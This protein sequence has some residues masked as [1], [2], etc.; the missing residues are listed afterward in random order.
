MCI[1][2]RPASLVLLLLCFC[3][4][5]QADG[6]ASDNVTK[7]IPINEFMAGGVQ[8]L[9]LRIS[10]PTGYVHADIK[11]PLTYSVWMPSSE[12]QGFVETKTFPVKT[13]WMYGKISLNTA[14]IR[15][16]GLFSG[17]DRLAQEM[18][19]IGLKLIELE[20]KTSLSGHP[21]LFVSML[22]ENSGAKTYNAYIATLI[23]T[24]VLFIAYRPSDSDETHGEPVW[25]DIKTSLLES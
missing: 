15:E 16:T 13:G 20:G 24:N 12:I 22:D 6:I 21:I 9:P 18:S 23:S 19:K 17:Q 1:N 7:L 14:Y 11:L 5:V 2:W 10:V 4:W 8:P 25:V 3:D